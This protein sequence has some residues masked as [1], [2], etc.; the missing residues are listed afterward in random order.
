MNRVTLKNK[1]GFKATSFAAWI[2]PFQSFLILLNSVF[3]TLLNGQLLN[4][5]QFSNVQL[6][7]MD[8]SSKTELS[9]ILGQI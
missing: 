3:N 8:K 2:L 1:N 6:N 4:L 7:P 9:Y 5:T